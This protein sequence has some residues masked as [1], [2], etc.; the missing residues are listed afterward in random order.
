MTIYEEMQAL[1]DSVEEL[2]KKLEEI[3]EELRTEVQDDVLSSNAFADA[4]NEAVNELDIRDEEII[5]LLSVLTNRVDE[6][7]GNTMISL[8][9]RQLMDAINKRAYQIRT[10]RKKNKWR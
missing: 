1:K 9:E 4:I 10:A 2:Q 7:S 6:L 8:R 3:K 5:L